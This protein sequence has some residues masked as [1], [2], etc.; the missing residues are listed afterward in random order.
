SIAG[1]STPDCDACAVPPLGTYGQFWLVLFTSGFGGAVF[2]LGFL[3]SAL[4]RSWRCRTPT[5]TVC[6][7]LLLF[8]GVEMFIYSAVGTP[9]LAMMIAIGLVCREQRLSGATRSSVTNA[10][11]RSG[12]GIRRLA[13][14]WRVV[15]ALVIV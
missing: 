14:R 4:L 6:T 3:A 2:Y 8:A 5:E 13:R 12:D 15:A 11:R 7:C 1:G 10:D 9:L